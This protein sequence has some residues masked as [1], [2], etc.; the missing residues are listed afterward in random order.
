MSILAFSLSFGSGSGAN[1][2]PNPLPIP[3][4]IPNPNPNPNPSTSA[5]R[6]ELDQSTRHPNTTTP[7]DQ[8]TFMAKKT[9]MKE[10]WEKKLSEIKILKQDLNNL[11]M[12]YL[13]VEGYKDAADKF[14]CESSTEPE[15]EMD[16]IQER[17]EIRSAIQRGMIDDG[18]SKVN[19]LNP[20]ILA[21]NK[22]LIFHLKKQR[23][24]E[25]IRDGNLD[26]VLSYAQSE[27]VPC[28]SEDNPNV[29]L[30][31]ELEK[32]MALLAFEDPKGCP[33]GD[34]L[35]HHQ[36]RSTA[37]RLNNAIL[38]SLNQENEPTVPHLLKMLQVSQTQLGL[39]VK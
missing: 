31:E 27:M 14:K 35:H 22:D 28:L 24:I 12:N 36:R 16:A 19:N 11:V 29:D 3:I 33:L 32:T 13:L 39:K 25:L 21:G 8:S 2:N 26:A 18:I 34:L 7:S 37:D 6:V 5:S 10:E 23:L 4:P 38:L 9:L 30:L 15:I 17:M 20:D 1:P